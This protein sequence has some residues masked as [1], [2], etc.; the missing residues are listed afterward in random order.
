[1]KNKS[2]PLCFDSRRQ[3]DLWSAAARRSPPGSSSYC[4]DCSLKYQRQMITEGRCA[5]PGTRFC[6]DGGLIEGRRPEEERI[7]PREAA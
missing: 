5:Y 3:F 2:G 6:K 7:R 4:T 1:M